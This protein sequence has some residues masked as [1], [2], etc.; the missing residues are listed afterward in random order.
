[1]RRTRIKATMIVAALLAA[2][3]SIDTFAAD[4]TPAAVTPTPTPMAVK[5]VDL[6]IFAG[7]SNMSGRGGD[8]KSA[9][10]V[11]VDTGY[12]FRMGTCPTGLYPV[13][14]PFGVYSNG[15]LCDPPI[16]RGGSLVSSFMNSYYKATGVP[17]MG[18]SA[19][20]GGSSIAYW[21]TAPV[22]AELSQKFDTIKAWCS[23]NHIFIRKKY[24]VWLQGE[25]D[26]VAR[27]DKQKYKEGLVNVFSPL[28][29][30]GLDQVFVITIGQYAGLPGT[31]DQV[32][33]A[34]LEL[35][36]SDP[37]FSLGSDALRNLPPTYLTD[38]CHY[39]QAA[40]NIVGSQSGS[41]AALYTKMRP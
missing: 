8:A 23:A 9:P 25:T 3:F 11:A 24:V 12:E 16:L 31:Y 27:I 7:Q 39:S 13:S 38:G 34:E 14:E 2:A 30:K 41:A 28:F 10:G 19:A 22:Q 6:V 17:V 5:T 4:I 18:F 1:M 26:G 20:R 29:S 33:S 37:R 36:Q 15:Y 40:L 21:Q 35:C 32:I